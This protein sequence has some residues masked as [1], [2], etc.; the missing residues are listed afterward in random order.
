MLDARDGSMTKNGLAPAECEYY[1]VCIL[2]K[3][4][5]G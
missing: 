2:N 1:K 5:F 4:L 3:R